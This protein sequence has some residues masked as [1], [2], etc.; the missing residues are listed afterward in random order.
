MKS[1][2]LFHLACIAAT[3]AVFALFILILYFAATMPG[4]V[5]LPLAIAAIAILLYMYWCDL[6]DGD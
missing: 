1:K 6:S 5:V 4:W 3:L 2:P